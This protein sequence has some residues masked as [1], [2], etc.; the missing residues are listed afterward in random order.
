MKTMN[1][2]L[3]AKNEDKKGLIGKIDSSKQAIDA[4]HCSCQCACECIC[5]CDCDDLR[6]ADLYAKGSADLYKSSVI[7]QN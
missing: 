7:Y 1:S 5:I 4:E 6:P 2:I 3:E